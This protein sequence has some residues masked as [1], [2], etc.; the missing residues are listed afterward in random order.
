MLTEKNWDIFLSGMTGCII[1][2]SLCLSSGESAS[3]Y[4]SVMRRLHRERNASFYQNLD[5]CI[6]L[7]LSQQQHLPENLNLRI[8][9]ILSEYMS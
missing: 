5:L 1:L 7:D 3:G 8:A 9:K 6:R 2:S 4:R